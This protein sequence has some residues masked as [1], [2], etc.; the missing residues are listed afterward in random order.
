MDAQAISTRFGNSEKLRYSP[1]VLR[2]PRS[3]HALLLS[4]FPD[5]FVVGAFGQQARLCCRCCAEASVGSPSQEVEFLL[6]YLANRG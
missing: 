3:N 2:S 1:V 4:R 6:R 5:N